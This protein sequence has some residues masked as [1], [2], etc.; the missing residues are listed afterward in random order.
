[1]VLGAGH[2]VVAARHGGGHR[3]RGLLEDG[4]GG[5]LPLLA[6]GHGGRVARRLH[7]GEVVEGAGVG[8]IV[9]PTTHRRHQA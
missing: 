9:A 4:G 1:M 3:G 6:G 5:G 7:R 8:Q 2:I